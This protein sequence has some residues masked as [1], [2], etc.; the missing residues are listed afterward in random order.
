[1]KT[2]FCKRDFVTFIDSR[3]E[4]AHGSVLC[5]PNEGAEQ[6]ITVRRRGAVSTYSRH[7]NELTP[8]ATRAMIDELCEL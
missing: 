5:V 2:T 4:R 7:P 3:N 6:T 8:V 1:M